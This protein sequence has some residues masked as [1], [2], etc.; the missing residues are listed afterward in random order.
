MKDR[1]HKDCP[2]MAV[3]KGLGT[4]RTDAKDIIHLAVKTVC[5]V[6][7]NPLIAANCIADISDRHDTDVAAEWAYAMDRFSCFDND[8]T[9]DC[10]K[11]I[12]AVREEVFKD[13][14]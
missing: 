1:G 4:E 13:V 7:S 2:L 6:A 10:F 5:V 8:E 9:A 12:M 11:A 3:M 14:D